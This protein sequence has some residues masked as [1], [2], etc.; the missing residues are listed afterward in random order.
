MAAR[1]QRDDNKITRRWCR[2]ILAVSW[3]V[4]ILAAMAGI[5][6]LVFQNLYGFFFPVELGHTW[7]EVLPL[8]LNIFGQCQ[9]WI[10][11][12]GRPLD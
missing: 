9:D 4:G 11:A 8:V 5:V 3:F 6:G 10:C 1:S 7:K 12:H 2:V